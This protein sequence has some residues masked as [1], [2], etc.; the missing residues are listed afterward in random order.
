MFSVTAENI[1]VENKNHDKNR[2]SS[3]TQTQNDKVRVKQAQLSE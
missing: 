3:M 1:W 2:P